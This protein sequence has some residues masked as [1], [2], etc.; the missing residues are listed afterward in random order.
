MRTVKYG[1]LLFISAIDVCSLCLTAQSNCG[2]YG[3]TI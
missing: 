3:I 1:Q 2:Y